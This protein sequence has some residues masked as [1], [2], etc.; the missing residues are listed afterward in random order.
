MKPE[1]G[2]ANFDVAEAVWLKLIFELAEQAP[3]IA[4]LCKTAVARKVLEFV[5]RAGPPIAE[6]SIHRIDALRAGSAPPSMRVCSA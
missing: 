2:L 1:P 3:T 6:A 5:H 4:L